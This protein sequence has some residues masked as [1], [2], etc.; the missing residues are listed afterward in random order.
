MIP[1]VESVNEMKPDSYGFLLIHVLDSF[2]PFYTI[3]HCF[4]LHF[5]LAALSYLFCCCFSHFKFFGA[6]MKNNSGISFV[7][8]LYFLMATFTFITTDF[9]LK[10]GPRDQSLGRIRH[11]SFL[12]KVTLCS[13]VK[14]SWTIWSCN[15]FFQWK[16][17]SQ[18]T[19]KCHLDLVIY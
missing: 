11:T 8:I 17:N 18:M 9:A 6:G 7:Y 1:K 13:I 4:F 16:P 5:S 2:S 15:F 14:L 19:L 12:T 10:L 3:G